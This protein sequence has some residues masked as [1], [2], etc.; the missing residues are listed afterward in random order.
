[1]RDHAGQPE[2]KLADELARSTIPSTLNYAS[3][4]TQMTA[5]TQMN[6][7]TAI[8][9]NRQASLSED[10]IIFIGQSFDFV[11]VLGGVL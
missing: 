2:N 6:H 10:P 5:L 9:N 11:R 4:F 7:L 1:M 8:Y 3:C